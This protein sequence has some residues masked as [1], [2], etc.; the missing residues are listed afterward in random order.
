MFHLKALKYS[1]KFKSSEKSLNKIAFKNSVN[2]FFGKPHTQS[3]SNSPEITIK[4]I[5]ELPLPSTNDLFEAINS[6]IDPVTHESPK[7]V[8]LINN[9]LEKYPTAKEMYADYDN[10]Y[11]KQFIV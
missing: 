2:D 6:L 8:E 3:F 7:I 1:S 4:K 11:K 9:Y 10:E 5:E